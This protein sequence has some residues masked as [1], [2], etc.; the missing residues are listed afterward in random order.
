MNLAPVGICTYTRLDHLMKTI[1]AL[2]ANTLAQQTELYIFSDGPRPGDE[3]KVQEL[4]DYLTTITGFKK[5]HPRLQPTNNMFENTTNANIQLTAAHGRSIFMEDDIVTSPH[6]LEFMNAGLDRYESNKSI[7]SIGGYCLPIPFPKDYSHDIYFS[8]V[9][10]P[11]GLGTW[12]DRFDL[13][14]AAIAAWDPTFNQGVFSGLKYIG[15]DMA[16]RYKSVCK[17]GITDR[18]LMAKF[19]LVATIIMLQRQMYTVL[20]TQTLVENIGLDGSG[21]HCNANDTKF[22]RK[23][24]PDHRPE[25]MTDRP[26]LDSRIGSEIYMQVSFGKAKNSAMRSFYLLIRSLNRIFSR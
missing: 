25:K 13:A 6:F 22:A 4:R 24:D 20:P 8:Q 12:K 7:F 9:F 18:E 5:V 1:E 19:D 3:A 14:S 26:F 16:R 11:W 23:L 2:K 21:L 10:C 17:P 15:K